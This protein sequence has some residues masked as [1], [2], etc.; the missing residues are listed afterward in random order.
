M[1][2]EQSLQREGELVVRSVQAATRALVEQDLE[3]A[4]EVIAF[5]D[6]IDAAL[7][8]DPGRDPVAARPADAG[9]VR[10]PARARDA[11]RQPAPRADGRLLRH[12][13]QA[14]EARRDGTVRDP[15]IV[16][17]LAEMGVRAEEMTRRRAPLVPAPR[18]GARRGAR[19]SRRADRP[20]EPAA[21]RARA[22]ARR[23]A[24]RVGPADAGRLALPRADRRPRRRHRRADRLPRH[25]RVPRVHG[26]L[27]SRRD[28]LGRP[29]LHQLI[30]SR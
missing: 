26:R 20:D 21:R 27:A 7:L 14:D 29:N 23:R 15:R 28:Q 3:L 22:R 9:R 1:G 5:D 13:R 6:E 12:G 17:A 19:R 24:P 2:L 16:A 8:R 10:P 25:R 11:A 30:A 18:P 4:D